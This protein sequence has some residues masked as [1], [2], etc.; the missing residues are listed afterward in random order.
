MAELWADEAFV[1]ELGKLPAEVQATIRQ[2]LDGLRAHPADHPKVVR[3]H[4]SRYPSSFRMRIGAHRVLG[5]LLASQDLVF[6]TTVF[7]KKRDSDYGQA[8]AR[9]EGRLAAQG[10]PLS[11][12]LRDA[13]RH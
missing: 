8:L 5:L 9:H 2:A 7:T 11:E 10:P 4:G 13:R 3:L 6:L 12:F 1:K